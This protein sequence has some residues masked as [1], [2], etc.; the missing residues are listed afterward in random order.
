MTDQITADNQAKSTTEFRG[1]LVR[2]VVIGLLII[3]IIPVLLIGTASY[4]RTRQSLLLQTQTQLET[5]SQNYAEQL[6]TLA[7]TRLKA[8]NDLNSTPNFDRNLLS[9]YS[10]P[11]DASYSSSL[12]TI[13]DYMNGYITTPTEKIFDQLS[14]VDSA[15]VVLVSSNKNLI[16]KVLTT[17]FF[18]NYLYQSDQ[19]V[20]AYNPGGLFP[21]KIVLVTTKIYRNPLGAPALT[22]IGF[23]TPSLLTDLLSTSQSI[24]PSSHPFYITANKAYITSS[25]TS[26][27]IQKEVVAVDYQN[28]LNN[29]VTA[30]KT[31]MVFEYTNLQGKPVVAYIKYIP[32]IKSSFVYEVPKISIYGQLQTLLPFILA[33]LAG[34]LIITGIAVGLSTRSLVIP[35]V[36]LAQHARDFASGDWSYRAKVNRRDEIG[37]LASSFNT[38]VDQLT[39]YTH[40]LEQK[41]E[42]RTHQMRLATEVAQQ[43][44]N[45]TSR[46]EILQK[47]TQLL[48]EKFDFPYAAIYLLDD[49]GE[50][51]VLTER[52]ARGI[53]DPL[54]DYLR[55]PV[56][57]N[58][59]L[60]LVAK[61]NQ[62][63]IEEN[64]SQ[65]KSQI[66]QPY[67]LPTTRSE[68]ILP[69]V[70]K[71]LVIGVLDI[72]STEPASFDSE[73][74]SIFTSLA[75]QV[76]VGLRNVQ[77]LESTQVN[78][79]EAT[80]LYRSSRKITSAQSLGEV[81]DLITG[82]F[83]QTNY[84]C[85]FMDIVGDELKLV[86]VSDPKGTRLD[87]TLKGF[88]IPFARAIPRLGEGVVVYIDDLT[89]TSE[90][91]NLNSYFERRNCKSAALIPIFEGKTLAHVLALGSREESPLSNMPLQPMINVAE[92]IGITMERIHLQMDLNRRMT[93]LSTL[94]AV[95]EITSSEEDIELLCS[96]LHDQVKKAIGDDV[97]FAIALNRESE[98]Q[99]EVPYYHDIEP[100]NV[101]P[102]AFSSDLLS[103][104]ILE[105][106]SSLYKDISILGLRPVDSPEI[107][108]TTKSW[109]SVPL[110]S[111][112][113][114]IGA[115]ALFDSRKSDRFTELDQEL[116]DTIAPQIGSSFRN[117]ELLIAQQKALSA[118]DQERFLLNTLLDNTP[119]RVAFKDIN[120]EFIRVSRSAQDLLA[121]NA[122]ITENQA[123]ESTD[124]DLEIMANNQAVMGEVSE[125]QTDSGKK[126]WEL[127]SKIPMTNEAGVVTGLLSISRDITDLKNAEQLAERR[128]GQLLTAAEIAKETST[129]SMN[130][131][132]TLKR[133]VDLVRSRFG[134][135]HSSIFLL[136]PSRQNA[137]LRESTGQAG[138]M[139]KR[140]GHKLAVGS[141]SI[142]GQTTQKA[143]P[144]LINDVTKEENYYPNPLLPDTRS[145]LGI[146]LLIS[147][148]VIG[149]LDVQSTELDAF[150]DEDVRILQ[151]L[152]DQLAV[153]IQNA[154]LFTKTEQTLSRHR[155]LHQITSAAGQSPTIEDA[156]RAAV[157]TLH[158][159]MSS[160]QITFFT[161]DPQGLLSVTAF[162]GISSIELASIK[163]LPGEK[164]VGTAAKERRSLRLDDVLLRPEY[165]PLDPNARSVLVV[166]ILYRDRLLGV[167]NVENVEIAAYDENDLEII[168]TLA[169]N[170]ASIMANIQLVDQVRL[171]VERQRQL[172]DI[173]SK[174]RRSVDVETIMKTSV[175]EICN[176]LNIKR[177]TIEITGV[178]DDGNEPKDPSRSLPKEK[179]Q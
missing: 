9:I 58:S 77:L 15:G 108:T 84:V 160:D 4:L 48:T 168:T 23:S 24:F 89:T 146:P 73:S 130:I 52:T 43:A 121:L 172:Y 143:R 106:K 29:Y 37:M 67:L 54:P 51:A 74:I 117:T 59:T 153:A 42:D 55:V 31:G 34:S 39:S 7:S 152:A 92:A 97:G 164:A 66:S 45:S 147:G 167:L 128:A 44:V 21:D 2:T 18:I 161:F 166:P 120:G 125:R 62:A 150:T 12:N 165:A 10:G 6:S 95:S 139:L 116:L 140:S 142:I 79:Q 136:D 131:D 83:A 28:N 170:L 133:L 163:I 119:D 101:A 69:I 17:D 47:T 50:N 64:V 118:Y 107:S 144:I 65:S 36:E 33:I 100:V 81:E 72:Q 27:G 87:Q 151:V 178:V 162:A 49:S 171:Q 112:G 56:N 94:A 5:I 124:R 123:D 91:S 13:T 132:E 88:T 156:I 76:S 169:N 127:T 158:Q 179:N 46:D 78:L 135:Y 90:Y 53:A 98:G 122:H 85:F 75:N 40:S 109:L 134:F 157:Q 177:A 103:T 126:I 71:D 113:Q 138:E 145:E 25:N 8:L 110:I 104:T 68:I 1:S 93:E 129:G 22:I 111:S 80:A 137:V 26:P 148:Q 60:G 149:A 102:Y 38:M 82:V 114:T 57:E 35:L 70:L 41:V 175:T 173:T 63:R 16:G 30:S 96:R 61:N 20:L 86:T 99:I 3:S 141:Q 11:T 115:M 14:I 32:S 159:T 154:N 176:A 19:N 174:I 155:L 105:K